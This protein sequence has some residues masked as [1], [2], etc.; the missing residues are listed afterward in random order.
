MTTFDTPEEKAIENIVEEGENAGP[1][2]RIFATLLKRNRT[3]LAT[4]E[5]L[6]VNAFNLGKTKILSK[7]EGILHFL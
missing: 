1:F 7:G 3:I 6:S 5:L 4:M 2:P